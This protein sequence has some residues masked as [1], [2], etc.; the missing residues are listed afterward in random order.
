M[1]AHPN[2][3]EQ[4]EGV[5]F[6]RQTRNF[7]GV[8]LWLWLGVPPVTVPVDGEQV[9]TLFRLEEGQHHAPVAAVSEGPG[10]EVALAVDPGPGAEGG[11]ALRPMMK[12]AQ[13]M[14]H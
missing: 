1:N 6:A 11:H 12:V 7:K 13:L 4:G 8:L 14:L 9:L 2:H 5:V 10:D 3:R